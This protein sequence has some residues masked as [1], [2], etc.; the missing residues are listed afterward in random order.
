MVDANPHALCE[1]LWLDRLQRHTLA[2]R[3]PQTGPQR[4]AAAQLRVQRS[5]PLWQ[6][7]HPPPWPSTPAGE[8]GRGNAVYGGLVVTA[9]SQARG[10][11]PHCLTGSQPPS[12]H[13][14]SLACY[15]LILLAGRPLISTV[16]IPLLFQLPKKGPSRKL[17]VSIRKDLNKASLLLFS[18]PSF[19][20]P[21]PPQQQ[22]LILCTGPELGAGNMSHQE[23]PPLPRAVSLVASSVAGMPPSVFTA[24]N[25]ECADTEN[26][27]HRVY[28]NQRGRENMQTRQSHA[29]L[30]CRPSS[31]SSASE[32]PRWLGEAWMVRNGSS[33]PPSALP[34]QRSFLPMFLFRGLT[35]AEPWRREPVPPHV[36]SLPPCCWL[37]LRGG[38]RVGL[39]HP[40]QLTGFSPHRL[41]YKFFILLIWFCSFFFLQQQSKRLVSKKGARK[42]LGSKSSK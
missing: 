34:C 14:D 5:P 26:S 4:R 1:W 28:A 9:F 6:W 2:G 40:R 24:S 11:L 25:F 19:F 23:N 22:S 10:Y 29:R 8:T 35:Q 30:L 18:L 3:S 7:Q 31:P 36:R 17:F 15:N 27:D 20:L 41:T 37:V 12:A 21:I 33:P 16:K 38:G 39:L 32:C 42:L 13:G